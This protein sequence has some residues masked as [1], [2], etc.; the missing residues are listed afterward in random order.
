MYTVCV[1][2]FFVVLKDM[3][4]LPTYFVVTPLALGQSRHCLSASEA[5]LW[6]MGILSTTIHMILWYNENKIRHSICTEFMKLLVIPARPLL[7]YQLHGISHYFILALVCIPSIMVSLLLTLISF[8]TNAYAIGIMTRHIG[9][10]ILF[11]FI[12]GF[13]WSSCLV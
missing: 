8:W 9:L 10:Y 12:T 4:V 2:L 1:L 6:S 5:P 13:E 3:S 7:R 11:H